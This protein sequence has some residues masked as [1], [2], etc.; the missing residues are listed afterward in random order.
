MHYPQ[1]I[2]GSADEWTAHQLEELVAEHRWKLVPVRRL[3]AVRSALAMSRP[4]VLLLQLD[5]T[6][7]AGLSLVMETHLADR[8][9][10]IVVLSETKLPEESRAVWT[11]S[12]MDLGARAVIFPPF[13]RAV[14]ED[15]VGGLM[16]AILSR[17]GRPMPMPRAT[18][19]IDLAD[20]DH[21][22]S[23]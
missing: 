22:A 2:V 14:L 16:A 5:P 23:E 10:A 21:E 1:V 13:T 6:S 3:D 11:A 7:D 15:L 19:T 4:T 8:D 17:Q 18:A 12:L 9:V 20:G